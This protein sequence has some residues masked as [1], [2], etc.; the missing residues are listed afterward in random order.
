MRSLDLANS[1]YGKRMELKWAGNCFSNCLAFRLPFW[2]S[3]DVAVES[4]IHSEAPELTLVA[5]FICAQYLINNHAAVQHLFEI[6]RTF[7]W[8]FCI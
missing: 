7:T 5:A 3:W 8:S 1:D 2:T 6:H 4:V